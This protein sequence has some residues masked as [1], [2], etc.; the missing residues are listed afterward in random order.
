MPNSKPITIDGLEH[1]I[2]EVGDNIN[3]HSRD[4]PV[5]VV[6]EYAEVVV[7]SISALRRFLGE[8]DYQVLV[9][10]RDSVG[11]DDEIQGKSKCLGCR[12]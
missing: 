9:S 2:A 10:G 7:L 3:C 4:A 11:Q 12:R 5:L 1:F 8:Q 6:P